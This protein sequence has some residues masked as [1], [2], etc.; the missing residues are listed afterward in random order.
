MIENGKQV[1]K[2][3]NYEKSITPSLSS[4][5]PLR[6]GTGGGTVLTIQGLNF[7]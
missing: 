7:P 1:E 6:G 5:L 2:D 4:V 3:F